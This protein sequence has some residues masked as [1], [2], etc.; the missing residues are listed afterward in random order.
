M[1]GGWSGNGRRQQK[2]LNSETSRDLKTP[3]T[4]EP[5]LPAVCEKNVFPFFH[6]SVSGKPYFQLVHPPTDNPSGF[7]GHGT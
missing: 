7:F 2:Q 4:L 1:E 6:P 5:I 3:R